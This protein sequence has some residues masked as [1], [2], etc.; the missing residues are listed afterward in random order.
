MSTS[1]LNLS[2]FI[3]KI[4]NQL[5]NTVFNEKQGLKIKRKYV[6]QF[7]EMVFSYKECDDM[8]LIYYDGCFDFNYQC[9]QDCLVCY[10]GICLKRCSKNMIVFE[11]QC[12]PICAQMM[13]DYE[14]ECDDYNN[15]EYHEC[16]N[17]KFQCA[18]YCEVSYCEK[19]IGLKFISESIQQNQ[20]SLIHDLDEKQLDLQ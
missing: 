1:L 13:V 14:I 10:K 11:N 3:L 19:G 20:Q 6:F 12:K 7:V 4:I 2:Q 9:S 16:F 8:N 18:L 5:Q 17:C 15:I